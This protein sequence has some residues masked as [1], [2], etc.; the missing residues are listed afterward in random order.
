[1][2]KN[3][4]IVTYSLFV[5]LI[6]NTMIS[7]ENFVELDS[8]KGQ[9][10]QTDVFETNQ[11]AQA[12][13]TTLY[14]LLRDNSLIAGNLPSAGFYMGIYSDELDSYA[15]ANSVA[16][17]FYR[18]QII[19]TNDGVKGIWT[20]TYKL[21]YE[22]NA[23]IEGVEKSKGLTNEQKKQYKAEAQFI[24]SLTYFYLTNLFG[25]IPFITTTDYTINQK[26]SKISHQNTLLKIEEDLIDS[27]QQFINL[28]SVTS[29]LRANRY[30]VTALL[31]RVYIYQQ[32]WEK[33]EIESS[34]LINSG[35]F[36]LENDLNKEFLKESR[37]TLFQM[38]AKAVGGNSNEGGI[39]IFEAGPPPN[40]C[41]SNI[42]SES[43]ETTDLRKQ[44]WTKQITSNGKSWIMPYK[45]KERYATTTSKEYTIVFRL[46]EQ[47]LI[48]SE[49]R[50]R[51]GNLN[52]AK[53]DLTIIR[54]R[55]GLNAITSSSSQVIFEAIVNER[56]HELFTEH[57]HRWFDLKRWKLAD[58]ALT[59]IKTNWKSTD[60]LLPIPEAELLINPNLLPQNQGY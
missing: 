14:A 52:G 37:S 18:H 60:V 56:Q 45:Y 41:L 39:Y 7:C 35:K 31:A 40:A 30:N 13:V 10:N 34:E 22:C 42:L 46:A 5:F 26:E 50:L 2:K 54:E 33:A 3:Q 23:V 24:R 36:Q 25:D 43:F 21:I 48:R 4:T 19:S 59:S 11:T 57:G 8:P 58:K 29:N 16:D 27:K 6:G 12:A 28:S 53:D 44:Y 17:L 1:M 51:L 20:N 9:L 49:A 38:K 32:K 55:A 15:A 47:Y